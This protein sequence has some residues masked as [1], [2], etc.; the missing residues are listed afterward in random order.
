M[1]I[2]KVG[3]LTGSRF[4]PFSSLI[5]FRIM[6]APPLTAD[7]AFINSTVHSMYELVVAIPGSTLAYNYL[8]TSYQDDPFRI[9]LE[10]FLVFFALRYMLSKKYKPHDNA[11]KLTEKVTSPLYWTT[12]LI[13]VVMGSHD[14]GSRRTC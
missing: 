9:A 13:M 1:L 11:V 5:I 2:Y 14:V 4:S 8:K 3:G 12:V 7:H 6:E 10:L